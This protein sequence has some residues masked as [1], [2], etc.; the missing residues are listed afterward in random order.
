MTGAL[1]EIELVGIGKCQRGMLGDCS[2]LISHAPG[3]GWHISISHPKR[4]PTYYEIKEARYSFVPDDVTMAMLFPPQAEF[5]NLDNHCF[6]L[7]QI[8]TE[9]E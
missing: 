2:V 8:W 9:T 5:V 7:F 1:E 6:H 3:E 4:D